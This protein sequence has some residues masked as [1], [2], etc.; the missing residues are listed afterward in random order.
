MEIPSLTS[1]MIISE[2]LIKKLTYGKG[3]PSFA[4]KFL[5]DREIFDLRSII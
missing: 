2:F 1:D 5:L 4:D 3:N